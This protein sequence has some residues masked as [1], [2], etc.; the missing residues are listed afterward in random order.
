MDEGYIKFKCNWKDSTIDY[1]KEIDALNAWRNIMREQGWIGMYP[2]GIGYGNISMRITD[3]TFLISGTATGGLEKLDERHYC[4]VEDYNL[5]HNEISCIGP[6]KASSESLTHALIY[7]TSA[8]T[9]AVIHIHNE[10]MWNNWKQRI[11]TSNEAVAYGTPEMALEI[12]RLFEESRL[13]DSK[14]LVMGGH[15]EGIIGFG[16]DLD[17]A[18]SKLLEHQ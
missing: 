3:H 15:P 18:G 10:Q 13:R 11:P 14:I 8:E 17:E 4:L 16:K 9:N 1:K 2:D 7:E 12:K 5:Q 6:I